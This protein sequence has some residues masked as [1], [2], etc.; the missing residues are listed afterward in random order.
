MGDSG[1][2]QVTLSASMEY[3]GVAQIESVAGLETTQSNL[4][5]GGRGV[6]LQTSSRKMS[7]GSL[8]HLSEDKSSILVVEDNGFSVFQARAL[9]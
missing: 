7:R 5:G 4:S 9:Q 3:E 1:P 2:C 8:D 6:H